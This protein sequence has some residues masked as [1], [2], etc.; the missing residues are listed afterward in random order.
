MVPADRLSRQLRHAYNVKRLSTVTVTPIESA[1]F[2]VLCLTALQKWFLQRQTVWVNT[3]CTQESEVLLWNLGMR[4]VVAGRCRC[5]RESELERE[6]WS[7]SRGT[8]SKNS[9]SKPGLNTSP[10]L[11]I[12]I[13]QQ[14]KSLTWHK[15][16]ERDLDSCSCRKGLHSRCCS[17]FAAIRW[18]DL[19]D[20]FQN[21][22]VCLTH[23]HTKYVNIGP[24]FKKY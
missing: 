23:L 22:L 14:T 8:A 3:F 2:W 20:R 24:S 5:K 6:V 21:L 11:I 4:R 19:L 17:R 12:E 18:G 7:L 15:I 1:C 16:S 9:F 10:T 13:R